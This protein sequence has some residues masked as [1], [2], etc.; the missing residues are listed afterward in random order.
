[1]VFTC[2]SFCSSSILRLVPT[3]AHSLKVA[4]RS[5]V[6]SV[7]LFTVTLSKVRYL[8]YDKCALFEIRSRIRFRRRNWR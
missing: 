5:H 2:K 3:M 8:E 6:A 1:M 7:I 4:T